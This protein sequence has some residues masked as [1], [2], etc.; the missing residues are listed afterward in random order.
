MKEENNSNHGKSHTPVDRI[1]RIVS[2][3]HE[4][5]SGW[6]Y[7]PSKRLQHWVNGCG[8]ENCDQ[9]TKGELSINCECGGV[10]H[11]SCYNKCFGS[12]LTCNA[13]G[14]VDNNLF[15]CD[16]KDCANH[17]IVSPVIF[18]RK[19][20]VVSGS[21]CGDSMVVKR[22]DHHCEE[23][24]KVVSLCSSCVNIIEMIK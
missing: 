2:W 21:V 13:K 3:F 19:I 17:V 6:H 1:E 12:A 23:S 15:F 8:C 10:A 4:T 22:Y 7:L 24:G 18:G 20:R 14:F 9:G 16:N 5:L 11:L